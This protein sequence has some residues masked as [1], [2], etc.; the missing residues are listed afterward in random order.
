MAE[1]IQS[2][3]FTEEELKEIQRRKKALKKKQR[4]KKKAREAEKLR[5]LLED[6]ETAAIVETP[7]ERQTRLYEKA[8]KK[9][10]FAP[11]MYRREDQADMYRQAAELFAKTKGYEQ[12]DEL[13]EACRQQA[14][15]Y[16]SLYVEETY[17]LIRE[18][19]ANAKTLNDCRKIRENLAAIADHKDVS[20]EAQVCA[21]LERRIERKLRNKKIGKIVVAVAVILVVLFVFVYIQQTGLLGAIFKNMKK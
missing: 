18:Q 20:A 8:K 16:R 9:M 11:H 1:E 3:E 7:E 4:E 12:S 6:E 10:S 14:E 17:V 19:L 5:V 21:Q 15:H 2:E 13:C